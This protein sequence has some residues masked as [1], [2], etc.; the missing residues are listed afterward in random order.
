MMLT[1][2]KQACFGAAAV[3]STCT[4]DDTECFCRDVGY[5]TSVTYCIE[6]SCTIAQDIF[7]M[8]RPRIS[9]NYMRD[10]TDT[11][12]QQPQSTLRVQCATSRF[13][14]EHTSMSF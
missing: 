1:F 9:H 4:A 6:T 5:Q 13:E 14:T 7:G 11:T 2:A 8:Y 12:L 3:N 10:E